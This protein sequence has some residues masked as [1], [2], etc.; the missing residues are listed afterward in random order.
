MGI[1]IAALLLLVCSAL[2]LVGCKSPA[3]SQPG[4]VVLPDRGGGSDSGSGGM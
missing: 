1:R 3:G 4:S 2:T